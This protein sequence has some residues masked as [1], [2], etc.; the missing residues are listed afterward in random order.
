[1]R[2][3]LLLAVAAMMAISGAS[4]QNTV[5]I[6]TTDHD[7]NISVKDLKSIEFNDDE[8]TEILRIDTVVIDSSKMAPKGF[9]DL[10]LPSGT[11]WA[12]SLF[13]SGS[14]KNRMY[15]WG[16]MQPD[17]TYRFYATSP[18]Q[19]FYSHHLNK[20]T[21]LIDKHNV[22]KQTLG[23]NYDYPTSVQAQ[24][25]IDN[26][27]V[28]FVA[29][30]LN[31]SGYVLTSK[32]NGNTIFIEHVGK[33]TIGHDYS[34]GL[35]QK[36]K[37]ETDNFSTVIWAKDLTNKKEGRPAH[38]ELRHYGEQTTIT[39]VKEN[40]SF[41]YG[42]PQALMAV[43]NPETKPVEEECD[44]PISALDALNEFVDLGLP[45]G[46]KWSSQY[47]GYYSEWDNPSYNP[48]KF[49]KEYIPRYCW[50]EL[51]PRYT[52][53]SA[54]EDY[55]VQSTTMMPAA[56]NVVYKELGLGFD[57]PTSEQ[58]NELINPEY[59]TIEQTKYNG[60]TKYITITSKINGN[61]IRLYNYCKLG[62]GGHY[63]DDSPLFWLK[64]ATGEYDGMYGAFNAN[65]GL[66]FDK[67]AYDYYTPARK[68]GPIPM[69]ACARLPIL[70]VYN[71]EFVDSYTGKPIPVETTCGF[72]DA[73]G[74]VLFG[75][76]LNNQ[77]EK[78]FSELVD[79]PQ[80]G[81]ELLYGSQASNYV[82]KDPRTGL[83]TGL[84]TNMCKL[85][86]IPVENS[87][88]DAFYSGGA[89]LANTWKQTWA[90]G[91]YMDQ[92]TFFGPENNGTALMLY[93]YNDEEQTAVSYDSRP[94]IAFE[95][96]TQILSM[97]VY[98]PTYLLHSLM[99]GDGFNT[100]ATDDTEVYL[101]IEGFDENHNS[102]GVVKKAIFNKTIK[103][104]LLRSN[105]LSVERFYSVFT[106]L[107]AIPA[108][109]YYMF[110]YSVTDDQKGVNGLNMPAYIGIDDIKTKKYIY[111]K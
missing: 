12:S 93:G 38:I 16:E 25:L 5:S 7:I 10:G 13:G 96:D 42:V 37:L 55:T 49:T 21:Q 47:L 72:E 29:D 109:R 75:A 51:L 39:H 3:K 85:L 1:M 107:T 22:I 71:G 110:N 106:G 70:P 108:S 90:D 68:A 63:D 50:G 17:S 6:K 46:T 26:V 18:V 14:K 88:G 92:L 33:N 24:E 43:Y 81:G 4:A 103:K 30:T 61:K 91:G 94:I 111:Q 44:K 78:K 41:D 97:N 101:I 45:S 73:E 48:S 74:T 2:K 11:K 34:A 95:E 58:F 57:I 56:N 36:T 31:T 67:E 62:G 20:N 65:A 64:D 83:I 59:T 28:R 69:P 104:N 66:F 87:F 100:P 53:T 40:T 79:D 8:L 32:I 76:D 105:V 35:L 23:R 9:V 60:Y 86:G 98:F 84:R 15:R 27:S 54:H 99:E 52:E 89:A 80:Y 102:T 77:V 19:Q 82:F